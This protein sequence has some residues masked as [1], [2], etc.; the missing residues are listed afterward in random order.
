M[1]KRC[2]SPPDKS[3]TLRVLTLS[4]SDCGVRRQQQQKKKK[5]HKRTKFL[6]QHLLAVLLILQVHNR[7]DSALH[8]LGNVIDVLWLDDG[9]R[10]KQESGKESET[11]RQKKKEQNLQL[12]FQLLGEVVLQVR[13]AEVAKN[14][15]PIRGI[16]SREHVREDVMVV[17]EASKEQTQQQSDQGLACTCRQGSSMPWTCQYRWYRRDPRLDQGEVVAS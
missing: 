10:K 1:A 4:R 8:G 16:L 13:A 11:R 7:T 12:L 15:F 9:L 5:K 2:N 3:A 6:Q 14:L 17:E